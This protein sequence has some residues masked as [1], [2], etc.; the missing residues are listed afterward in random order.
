M[1]W[2]ALPPILYPRLGATRPNMNHGHCTLSLLRLRL[3]LRDEP[4]KSLHLPA[5][6]PNLPLTR[7]LSP[8]HLT[9][10]Q[11][12]RGPSPHL[13]SSPVFPPSLYQ[14]NHPKTNEKMM[15]ATTMMM[16]PLLIFST[17]CKSMRMN[18]GSA[19]RTFINDMTMANS[20]FILDACF[21]Y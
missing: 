16:H 21:H 1:I 6:S 13:A 18:T 12:R 9:R 8:Y 10:A 19:Q 17:I 2:T 5:L 20:S 14:R 11:Q 15:M 7:T 3:W 4:H